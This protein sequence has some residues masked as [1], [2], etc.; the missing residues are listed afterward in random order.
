MQVNLRTPAHTAVRAQMLDGQTAE[1]IPGY[2]W[3]EAI[4][5]SGDHLFARVR[6]QER[7]DI[8]ELVGRPVR[9]EL[10]M[11]EA[12]LFAIRLDCQVYVGHTPTETL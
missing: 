8:S 10:A 9:V 6:W 12:E 1:P 3:E 11:R 7:E 4:P 5:I 2:T